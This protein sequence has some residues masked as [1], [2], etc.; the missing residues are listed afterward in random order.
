MRRN[1]VQRFMA[2]SFVLF[3]ILAVLNY[4]KL[5]S[6]RLFTSANTQRDDAQL[7]RLISVPNTG[8][9]DLA[10]LRNGRILATS[11]DRGDSKYLYLSDDG[12]KRW[13]T[14]T[15][16]VSGAEGLSFVDETHGWLVGHGVVLK[17]EDAGETWSQISK[18]TNYP[19]SEVKFINLRDGYAAGGAERGCQVFRTSDGGE[20][21]TKIYE[22]LED[23]TVF[24]I[25]VLDQ[26]TVIAA[27]N[28]SFLLRSEDSG[29]TW[30]KIGPG[31]RGASAVSLG[32]GD[33]L[34]LVG[35][36]G[37]FSYSVDK[38]RTWQS[39]M[40][41]TGLMNTDWSA[42][43][44]SGA[45]KGIAVGRRS[46]I[47]ITD[48]GGKTWLETKTDVTDDLGPV[49]INED[50]ALIIGWHAIYQLDLSYRISTTKGSQ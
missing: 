49:Q 35:R 25:E 27:I 36:K 15:L 33:I 17:T 38:G 26:K 16:P 44:F 21:W 8:F 19:L 48:D 47:A 5:T 13:R 1:S 34:W 2:L 23:G 10:I 32:P 45:K 18:P 24:D 37:S 39:A 22:N 31:I 50:R 9:I 20:T 41:P 3:A 40:L 4:R 29:T 28:D 43:A 12:G 14:V 6:A 46:I 11:M 42:I 30:E 7:K